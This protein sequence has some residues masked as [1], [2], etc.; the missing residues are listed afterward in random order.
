MI[1]VHDLREVEP[2]LLEAWL[3]HLTK[4]LR[5]SDLDE[6]EAMAATE[7]G[8]AIRD[9][10]A[11]SSHGYVIVDRKGEPVAIFGVAPHPLPGVGVIW[12]LG[13]EGIQRE[14]VSI[15][16]QTRPYLEHLNDLYPVLWNY[17]DARNTVSMR[18]LRWGGFQVLGNVS[19][20]PH[21]FHIF[22]R[23]NFDV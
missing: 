10:L 22:A 23:T 18:W 13:T 7:P 1:Q 17:I 11:V 12:M 14:A 6:I 15:G 19:F 20:G 8:R 2:D 4:N 9:S 21:Q 16:R 3:D 5:Q